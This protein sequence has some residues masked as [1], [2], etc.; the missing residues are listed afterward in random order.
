MKTFNNFRLFGILAVLISAI[1]ITG[2]S[3]DDDNTPI[4]TPTPIPLP[5]IENEEEVITDVKL[6]FTN[7]VD[8]LDVVMA[9]AK[10]PDGEGVLELDVL[11][12]INLDIN[13]SYNLTF[14]IFNNLETPGEDIGAEIADEDHEHQLFYS[15]TNNAFSSPSGNGNIDNVSD[16][17]NYNDTDEN[18]LFVGLNTTWRTQNTLS[19][20]RFTIK[21]QHQPDGIKTITSNA[22]DG[23][24]D[25]NLTFV[26]N[27][28]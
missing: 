1:T 4:T 14:E 25:F 6:I 23:D 18:N 8:T 3:D 19:D 15:F 26:L 28:N 21:L 7:Q 12:T 24:T 9:R 2:C 17:M 13:K 22:T 11:D 27:I 5:P 10:D 20:G 16:P